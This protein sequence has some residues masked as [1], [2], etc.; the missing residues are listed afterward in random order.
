MSNE[1]TVKYQ[2]RL[3]KAV[4]EKINGKIYE[5]AIIP[6]SLVIFVFNNPDELIIIKERRIWEEPQIRVKM[7]TGFYE[8][9]YSFEENVNREL[10]E[11]IGKK[12]EKIVLYDTSKKR[13]TITENKYFAVAYNLSDSKIFNED[14][15]E[16]FLE[17]IKISIDDLKNRVLSRDWSVNETGYVFLR[18]YNEIKAGIFKFE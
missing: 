16:N 10:Q 6:D 17:I 12:A 7:V 4:E 5:K 1:I 11:E 18:L 9:Q 15:D 2:G 14:G 8:S 3:I 13:G